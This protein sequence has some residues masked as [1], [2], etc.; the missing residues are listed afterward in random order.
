MVLQCLYTF[1]PLSLQALNR[2]KGLL[3]EPNVMQILTGLSNPATLNMLLASLNPGHKQGTCAHRFSFVGCF[4]VSNP[5][6]ECHSSLNMQAC[7]ELR[8]LYLC[9]QT[10]PSLLPSCSCC[11]RT[12]SNR[13]RP[14]LPQPLI[15]CH[16][17]SRMCLSPHSLL[18][19]SQQVLLGNPLLWA[20]I[21]HNKECSLLPCVSG[22][23]VWVWGA[24]VLG[25]Y[26][27]F[28]WF[29]QIS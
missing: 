15:S 28:Q 22:S 2:G 19:P 20:H 21:L 14:F 1:L 5:G 9:W 12:K 24:C 23:S 7:W 29:Y 25:F 10:L 3:P 4:F 18:L 6:S 8:P 11:S 16:S 26:F 17:P 13:Y 27:Y